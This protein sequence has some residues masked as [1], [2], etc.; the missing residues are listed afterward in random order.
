MR[1]YSVSKIIGTN[2]I[3]MLLLA[4]V[5][6]PMAFAK[7]TEQTEDVGIDYL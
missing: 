1:I 5:S 7:T 3:F 2:I 4:F 6:V